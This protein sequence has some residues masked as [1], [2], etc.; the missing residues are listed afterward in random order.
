MKSFTGK[1]GSGVAGLVLAAAMWAAG[2]GTANAYVIDMEGIAAPGSITTESSS[3]I[4][5]DFVLQTGHGHY[6]DSSYSAVLAGNYANN[7]TDWLLHDI[8]SPLTLFKPGAQ[9][10]ALNSIDATFYAVSFNEGS[11]NHDIVVTG[12][13]FGGG[14]VTTTLT[15]D[16]NPSFQTFV[17]DSGWSNL[18]SVS[19]QNTYG[20]MAYDNITVNVVVES[21]PEPAA[22]GVLGLGLLGLA[23]MRRRRRKG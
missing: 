12:A 16:D 2:G 19:F 20:A 23:A 10:F 9:P 14:T 22:L 21:V 4:W 3:R 8:N 18:A 6:V 13:I 15:I 7:G 17:F 5:G 11:F 1:I